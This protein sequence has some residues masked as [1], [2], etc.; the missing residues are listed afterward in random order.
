MQ[1]FVVRAAS[2]QL[3]PAATFEPVDSHQCAG[4]ENAFEKLKS[5]CHMPKTLTHESV[6]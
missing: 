2:V 1:P 4:L 5:A 6:T 3:R